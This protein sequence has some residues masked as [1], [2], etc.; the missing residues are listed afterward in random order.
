MRVR[1]LLVETTGA[2][3]A[4]RG[5]SLLTILGIVIGIGAVISMTALIDGVRV[6]LMNQLGLN[7]ARLVYMNVYGGQHVSLDDVDRFEQDMT[8][9]DFITP[10]QQTG[11][12]TITNG[13]NSDDQ[14]NMTG[15]EEDYRE[16]GALNLLAGRWLTQEE[17]DAGSMVVVV[18]QGCVAKLWGSGTEVS[19]AVGQT[20][21]IGNDEYLVVGVTEDPNTMGQTLSYV[22]LPLKTCI[23]RVSGYDFLDNIVGLAKEGTDMDVLAEQTKAYLANYYHLSSEDADNDIY[24]Y[25]VKSMMD[26]LD[27]TMG[28]FE[29]I[30]GAVAGVSLL[31]GG[32]GIMNMMLTNV[33]ERI[34]EIG[35][36]KALG[37]RSAD[38]TK[39]FLLESI[40]LCLVGGVLGIAA[41]YAGAWVLAGVA[42]NFMGAN[43]METTSIVP[44]I[45]PRSVALAC[46]I[47]MLIGIV[48]GFY[49]ARRAA[50]LN[51]VESLRYQ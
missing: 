10:T 37:A 17:C 28:S 35:L 27:A 30:L 12:Q 8:A 47:S 23:A 36:R 14:A 38:I 15:C 48:F 24:V 44:V 18:G 20:L 46:G 16:V 6:T 13:Q 40:G 42:G 39:Q 9:Y 11:G 19:S 1:D 7:Q 49:P 3:G 43:G 33:T 31:V 41:G 22:Y 5:R 4:N 50:K 26:S 2:I 32:I 45:A 34:R 25:T 21:R 29:L 51:P